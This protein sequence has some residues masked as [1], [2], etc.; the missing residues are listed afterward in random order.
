MPR[1]PAGTHTRITCVPLIAA[2]R[3]QRGPTPPN[4]TFTSSRALLGGS[5]RCK[6]ASTRAPDIHWCSGGAA[7]GARVWS[8]RGA[9]SQRAVDAWASR[10]KGS[11]P[12]VDAACADSAAWEAHVQGAGERDPHWHT[13]H[14]HKGS[15]HK[16]EAAAVSTRC[17]LRAWLQ[18]WRKGGGTGGAAVCG[19]ARARA[20]QGA[21]RGGGG[22]RG[23]GVKT[24]RAREREQR[25][26]RGGGK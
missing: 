11:G 7:A 22:K 8:V 20:Q 25:V 10:A 16:L 5:W 18:P 26:S 1:L 12:R 21:A 4:R 23:G 14:T 17:A 24:L 13:P 19:R 3:A 2:L 6:S 15:L 9:C